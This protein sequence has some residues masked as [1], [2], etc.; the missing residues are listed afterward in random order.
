MEGEGRGM[1]KKCVDKDKIFGNTALGSER[2][3]IGL[4][5]TAGTNNQNE[6]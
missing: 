6:L 1:G 3:S 4:A 2:E 5:W